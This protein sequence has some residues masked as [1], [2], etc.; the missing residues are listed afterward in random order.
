MTILQASMRKDLM[1]NLC[2]LTWLNPHTTKHALSVR[3]RASL[4]RASKTQLST[5]RNH[6]SLDIT[7]KNNSPM[8][9]KYCHEYC[10]QA[11][12][13]TSM[14]HVNSHLS[15]ITALSS[16]VSPKARG[17]GIG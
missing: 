3:A 13:L 8:A 10:M 9:H 4:M 11:C 2:L 15:A 14:V 6:S 5:I 7:R 12:K 1:H 16:S 17:A